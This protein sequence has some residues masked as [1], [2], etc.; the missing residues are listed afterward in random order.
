MK[1]LLILSLS[2]FVPFSVLAFSPP[3]FS[4]SNNSYEL[5]VDDSS[6]FVFSH[7]L[8]T[9]N[10]ESS[11]IEFSQ[12]DLGKNST[13]FINFPTALVADVV[14]IG[15]GSRILTLGNDIEVR[16]RVFDGTEF[17]Q[18]NQ[19]TNEVDPRPIQGKTSGYDLVLGTIDTRHNLNLHHGNS[20]LP[21]VEPFAN[22]AQNARWNYGLWIQNK[23][24]QESKDGTQGM[25]G[26]AGGDGKSGGSIVL[27]AHEFFGGGFVT[28]GGNGGRGGEGGV[29]QNGG[30]NDP[31]EPLGIWD[32][33]PGIFLAY[34]D[35]HKFY[36][37][38]PRFWLPGVGG[39]GGTGGPGGRGGNGGP[40]E[41]L[42]HHVFGDQKDFEPTSG[43]SP[44]RLIGI[45]NGGEAGQSGAPGKGGLL[46]DLGWLKG[47]NALSRVINELFPRINM[48]QWF[49][50]N[51]VAMLTAG[52]DVGKRGSQGDLF[53]YAIA[54]GSAGNI[55]PI[56]I[57]EKIDWKVSR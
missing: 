20:G 15:E 27:I 23:S 28:A 36:I 49:P 33:D 48:G 37:E 18:L 54:P 51:Y 55:S 19:T 44:S 5:I 25:A 35:A 39:K 26:T 17:G 7:I 24:P 40:I 21:R 43:N 30:D 47:G 9:E 2:L 32:E 38:N 53:P 34:P 57:S 42:S 46:G 31:E 4:S 10:K 1:K 41:I 14:R 11:K 52:D 45:S 8:N 12:I 22:S 16:T 50:E 6:S 3:K 29:G 56:I 13:G